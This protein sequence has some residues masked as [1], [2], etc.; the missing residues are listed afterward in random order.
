[1]ET[2]KQFIPNS[3]E[4]N[5]M[6]SYKD[7]LRKWLD[8]CKEQ[9]S[10]HTRHEDFYGKMHLIL[11]IVSILLSSSVGLASFVENKSYILNVLFGCLALISSTF[12][13]V[14]KFLKYE[15]L[16]EKHKNLAVRYKTIVSDIEY[17]LCFDTDN[18]N[19]KEIIDYIQQIKINM[20]TLLK[21]SPSGVN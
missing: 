3:L 9:C 2:N 12:Y 17:N 16:E 7:L 8:T 14:L 10:V 15:A 21:E 19:S 5:T 6:L 18:K 4:L 1:M 13:T 11:S 20:E